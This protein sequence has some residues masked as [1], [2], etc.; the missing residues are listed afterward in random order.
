MAEWLFIPPFAISVKK[1]TAWRQIYMAE[2]KA[3]RGGLK[4]FCPSAIEGAENDND[5]ESGLRLLPSG[6]CVYHPSGR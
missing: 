3:G 6:D 5:A 4:H 1:L 2:S